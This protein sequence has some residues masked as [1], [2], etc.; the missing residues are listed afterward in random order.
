MLAARCAHLVC[1]APDPCEVD[2]LLVVTFTEAAAAEMKA[3]IHTALR[4]RAAAGNSER[5]HRQVALVDRASVST[6]HSF[7]ARLLREYFHLVGLDPAFTVLAGEEA[8][9]LRREVA[10]SL[11]DDRYELDAEGDFQRFVDAYGEGDDARLMRQVIATHEML[12]SLIDPRAWIDGSL[13][14]ISEAAEAPLEQTELGQELVAVVNQAIVDTESR[15]E[16]AI[17]LVAGLKT[18]PFYVQ[19]LGECSQIL[20]FWRET[21]ATE[22]IDALAELVSTL[23]LPRLPA[24]KSSV[25][26]KELAK[27]AVDSVRDAM[28]TSGWRDLLRFT[29]AD[30]QQGLAATLPHAKVFLG[31]VEEFGKQY[32]LAK[33]ASRVVDFSDLERLALIVLSDGPPSDRKPSPAARSYHRR[34]EH[35]LVD[36]Y[37]DIN[38]VQDAIL[39]LLS[40]EC[41]HGETARGGNLFC[42]GDV[43]QSIYRF[44]LAEAAR[45]LDRQKSFRAPSEPRRGEVID[46]QANF[47][48]RAALLEAINAVFERLMSESAV[49]IEYDHSHRLHPGLNYPAANGQN[50]FSG[51]PIEMHLLPV[52]LSSD[53]E[54]VSD[55]ADDPELDRSEREAV[56]VAQRIRQIMGMDGSPPT[57]VAERN[58]SGEMQSR[59]IRFGD[60]V[61]LLRSIRYKAQQYADIIRRAGIPIHAQSATG[62]FES[63]E[64]RDMLALLSLLDNQRQDI[65][66]ATVLRSPLANLP[67]PEDCL[68]RIRLA[69]PT[70]DDP[71]IPF[72]DAVTLYAKQMDDEL[73]ARIQDFLTQLEAWRKLA[74]RRPLAELIHTIYEQSGYLAYCAGLHDGE[75]RVA[76]LSDLYQR[77]SQFGSFHRQS[78]S[79]FMEFLEGLR[80]EVD[81]GQPSIASEADD[82]V[83][84]MSIHRSKGLE[85]P[86]V[87]LPD[88]GKKINFADCQGSILAERKAGLGMA[89]IDVERMIRYPSLA[90]VLVQRRLRQQSLAE[91]LRVLYV[92]MTRAREH[93]ILV[94]TCESKT[95]DSWTTKWADQ[96]GAFPSDMVLGSRSLLDWLG[97]TA[98]AT[99]GAGQPIIHITRHTVEEVASWDAAHARRPALSPEQ[100]KLAALEELNPVP[101]LPAE[102][103]ETIKRLEFN[104]PFAPFTHLPATQAVTARATFAA[105]PTDKDKAPM[106]HELAKPRFLAARVA[107]PADIGTSTHLVLA[108][109]DF[110]RTCD[111]TDL[112]GQIAGMVER[113]LITEAQAGVVDHAGLRWLVDSELGDLLGKHAASLRREV[114]V[115]FVGDAPP[116]ESADPQDRIMIRG[117][118]DVLVPTDR[119]VTIVDYKTDNISAENVRFRAGD[120]AGQMQQYRQALEK[121]SG[122]PVREIFLAFLAPRVI[123]KLD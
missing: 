12:G 61:I 30:W 77:A 34:F 47:R 33:E 55:G 6:L 1:D 10:R 91:E 89:V 2:S 50:F 3:R 103:A 57:F 11:F 100:T 32:R 73:A 117:R 18:F 16:R 64:I 36:E 43:K 72:H 52:D 58:A 115:N 25:P 78:L 7:C 56:L 69:F 105:A 28:K 5:L 45:F 80:D 68:A 21:L 38:E 59:P 116:L 41:V 98:A 113:H 9:L 83:R 114:P 123:W 23:E 106:L 66:L 122:A 51:S 74:H 110:S 15:C 79:R 49:D 93:L 84:V 97:P 96:N 119:G 112:V 81:L 67:V 82:A 27:S 62:Y 24:V 99:A 29:A 111:A 60:I 92:A 104:Y 102:A 4:E 118:I 54:G 108:H 8:A 22:G 26:N 46:L 17:T 88:L 13:N 35:V 86:V 90:S 121:I 75:Q 63:T 107:T 87:V 14:R 40:R 120:Y 19:S 101:T 39:A 95:V 76:N 71:V 94:G 42:V 85:Y 70:S 37:Q 44:R 53:D 109:L 20:R 31:L 65:P 48:S